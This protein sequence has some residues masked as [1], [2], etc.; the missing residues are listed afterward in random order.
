[1]RS[2]TFLSR[3]AV[4]LGL[5]AAMVLATVPASGFQA[6]SKKT[7]TKTAAKVDL[8]KATAAQLAEL[9][10]VGPVTAKAIIDARPFKSVNEL[11]RVK[12]LGPAKIAELRDL[13]TVTAPAPAPKAEA[14][15]ATAKTKTAP[16][17]G[18]KINVNTAS[19]QEIDALPGIG[20]VKAKAIID[21]RPFKSVDDLLRVKGIGKETLAKI[22]DRVTVQ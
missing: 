7:A 8:N 13:V 5:A 20:P 14:P 22:R 3:A 19:L 10:G 2:P 12:G 9:P 21:A 11:E 17:A 18:K 16:P 6:T 4:V 15:K 1:M